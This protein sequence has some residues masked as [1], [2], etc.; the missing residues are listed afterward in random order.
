MAAERWRGPMQICDD[1][2]VT[3]SRNVVLQARNATGAIHTHFAC[4][5]NSMLTN[6]NM[7]ARTDVPLPHCCYL[8]VGKRQ[9]HRDDCFTLMLWCSQCW[10]DA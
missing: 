6:R 7:A 10:E 8:S 4:A 2:A 3:A 1:E 9:A 5:A